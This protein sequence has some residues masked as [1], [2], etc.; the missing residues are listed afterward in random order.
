M[1]FDD[2]ALEW[3]RADSLSAPTVLASLLG[4]DTEQLRKLRAS[5][6][7]HPQLGMAIRVIDD[8]SAFREARLKLEQAR[9]A[10]AQMSVTA[11]DL[12]VSVAQAPAAARASVERAND[13]QEAAEAALDRAHSPRQKIEAAVVLELAMNAVRQA[14]EVAEAADRLTASMESMLISTQQQRLPPSLGSHG[15]PGRQLQ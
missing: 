10:A 1:D 3:S 6:A 14:H 5:V 9:D 2:L 11:Q 7:R 15:K 8:Y 4:Y 12:A 13:A